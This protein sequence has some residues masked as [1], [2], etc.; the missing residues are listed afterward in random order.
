M[1][2]QIALKESLI[3]VTCP[4]ILTPFIFVSLVHSIS[5]LLIYNS[6]FY[7]KNSI[8]EFYIYSINL[9]ASIELAK[10]GPTR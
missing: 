7:F 1:F 4:F 10:K 8:F 5:I 3:A 2:F 6:L 9:S